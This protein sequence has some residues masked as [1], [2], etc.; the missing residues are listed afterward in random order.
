M[1]TVNGVVFGMLVVADGA[2]ILDGSVAGISVVAVLA[3]VVD[4]PA[5]DEAASGFAGFAAVQGLVAAV[6]V[7][8]LLGRVI[9]PGS[10]LSSS[11]LFFGPTSM[12][13][14]GV[15]VGVAALVVAPGLVDWGALLELDEAVL[16]SVGSSSVSMWL[17]VGAW[18][19]DGLALDEAMDGLTV[20]F[21]AS[22][23]ACAFFSACLIT[24][25]LMADSRALASVLSVEC[26]RA[27]FALRCA[28]ARSS[29]VG[30]RLP[31]ESLICNPSSCKC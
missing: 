9:N 2:V 18:V 4:E 25:A 21:V 19:A 16:V 11:S 12:I 22:S 29:S 31:L 26:F 28:F 14:E 8:V 13:K 30:G 17:N 5:L 7:F 23:S 1:E 15:A 20:F 6:L 27:A 24:P 3:G 10:S